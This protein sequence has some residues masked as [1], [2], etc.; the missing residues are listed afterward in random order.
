[1][2]FAYLKRETGPEYGDSLVPITTLEPLRIALL[3]A[4]TFISFL[5]DNQLLM[6]DT[7]DNSNWALYYPKSMQHTM[8]VGA[9]PQ[10]ENLDNNIVAIVPSKIGMPVWHQPGIAMVRNT[11]EIQTLFLESFLD[12]S[13]KWLEKNPD[14]FDELQQHMQ[15]KTIFQKAV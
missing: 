7:D 15:T 2:Q 4:R 6:M 3:K 8:G 9:L 10:V 11:L 14:K 12:S 5:N 13:R 1:M